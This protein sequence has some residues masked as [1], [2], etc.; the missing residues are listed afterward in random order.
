[1]IKFKK[2]SLASFFICFASIL[3]QASTI[4]EPGVIILLNGGNASISWD[5]SA[6]GAVDVEHSP[7]LSEWASISSYNANGLF[8]HSIGASAKGF[9]RLKLKPFDSSGIMVTTLAG[10]GRAVDGIGTG[11]SFNNPHG[12]ASDSEGNVYVADSG[13]AKI[14]KITPEGAVTTLAGSGFA[15]GSTIDGL[16]TQ[17]TFK[18]PRGVAV[19]L[20]GNVYVTDAVDNKVRKIS[21]QGV[22]TTLAGTGTEGDQDGAGNQAMLNSPE[23]IAVDGNGTVYVVDSWNN[24]IRKITPGG[25]VTTLAGNGERGEND[26]DGTN[27]TFDYPDGISIDTTGNLYVCGQYSN[28]IRKIAPDGSV[29]TVY[30]EPEAGF[31]GAK[32]LA[33]D[34]FRNFYITVGDRIKKIL[35]DGQVVALAGSGSS[36]SIDGP[37]EIAEF[38]YPVGLALDFQGNVFVADQ[39]NDKIRK[40]DQLGV[41]STFA[42]FGNRVDGVGNQSSFFNPEWVVADGRGNVFVGD[43]NKI[44]K[45][46]TNGVVSSFVGSGEWTDAVDGFGTQASF[47]YI[48]GLA[49]D[50][51]GNIY[52]AERDN[53]QIRKVSPDGVV[54]TYAGSGERGD[55]DGS[56]TNATFNDPAGLAVDNY[57]NLYVVDSG[58]KKIRKISASGM[59]STVA[60]LED[61]SFPT[62]IAVNETGTLFVT[63]SGNHRILKILGGAVS[64]FAGFGTQGSTDGFGQAASFN[65]PVGISIDSSGNLYV[66]DYLGKQ[67]RKISP[68]GLVS[69]IAG[70]GMQ[71][72][73][74]GFG[75]ATTF[76]FPL[77]LAVDA[78]GN[79]H[80]ADLGN[81]KIRKII[82]KK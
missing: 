11:A 71:G 21:S 31:G 68:E 2:I 82:I 4:T 32:G 30:I 59:V 3:C 40:I 28:K 80:V 78:F 20:S 62:G 17:A 73:I 50:H 35:P 74:D 14:R 39:S 1:M 64:T 27:A 65:G 67:I 6:I 33:I 81:A 18:W 69:T 9:Y 58:S 5:T 72:A 76:Y 41:V 42:G 36:G 55:A 13:N 66:S 46:T 37:G 51:N 47:R 10:I 34:R 56:R 19:D 24:K 52:A 70:T 16:A 63:D 48:S 49:I 44:R 45:V 22:V 25:M 53:Q 12:L 38:S 26:G 79:I 61:A 15:L 43:F 77:G 29:S 7:D 54:S 8:R 60:S 75:T 23:G 57:S